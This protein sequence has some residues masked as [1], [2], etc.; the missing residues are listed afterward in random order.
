MI[1]N[2]SP[3]SSLAKAEQTWIEGRKYFDL[4]TDAVLRT[5]AQV[6]RQRLII[7]ALPLRLARIN[8]P[9]AARPGAP[10]TETSPA[11][12]PTVRDTLD[13]LALQRWLHEAKQF[14]HSYWDGGNW[15]ECTEDAK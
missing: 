1:W 15:H 12:S 2:A 5:D 4:A 10:A 3:L 8:A 7:K 6:E 11:V 9:A 13:Y 14:R